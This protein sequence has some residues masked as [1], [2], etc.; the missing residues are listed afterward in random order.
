MTGTPSV[1]PVSLT[2][3]SAKSF[4]VDFCNS[5]IVNS[6]L[7]FTTELKTTSSGRVWLVTQRSTGKEFVLKT[8]HDSLGFTSIYS[9]YASL[10]SSL[11]S[12][13]CYF[14][15]PIQGFTSS[16]PLGIV[17]PS[18]TQ[19]RTLRTLLRSGDPI[20]A[21]SLALIAACVCYAMAYLEGQQLVHGSLHSGKIFLTNDLVPIV[22]DYGLSRTY[23][24]FWDDRRNDQIAW[25]APE[26]LTGGSTNYSIDVYSYGILLF[27]LFESRRPFATLT[28]TEYLAALTAGLFDD[29]DFDTTPENWR[30][31]IRQCTDRASDRRPTF[32]DLYRRLSNCEVTW[33]DLTVAD[34]KA[35]VAHYPI[36]LIVGRQPPAPET[37][38]AVDGCAML[39]N[40][41]HALFEEYIQYLTVALP[42][43]LVGVLCNSLAGYVGQCQQDRPLIHFLLSAVASIAQR[44]GKFWEKVIGS[45]FFSRLHITTLDEADL[46][47]EMLLPVF[48]TERQHF[49]PSIFKSI[50]LLFVFHANEALN[51]MSRYV[52]ATTEFSAGFWNVIRFFLGL[53]SLFVGSVYGDRYVRI[54]SFL[55]SVS[56]EF[57]TTFVREIFAILGQ[58]QITRPGLASLFLVKWAPTYLK[59]SP[60]DEIDLA[61]SDAEWRQNETIFLRIPMTSPSQEFARLLIKR[62]HVS[63]SWAVL[64]KFVNSSESHARAIVRVGGWFNG[65]N[66]DNS[67]LLLLSMFV[68]PGVRRDIGR[69]PDFFLTLRSLCGRDDVEVLH[70]ICSLIQRTAIDDEFVALASQSGFLGEYLKATLE[71]EDPQVARFGIICIDVCARIAYAD[72]W[73]YAIGIL[74]H[75]MKTR[76]EGLEDDFIILMSTMSQFPPCLKLMK[77]EGLYE[78]FQGLQQYEN[79]QNCAEFFLKNA[80][81][82]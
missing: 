76:Y 28:N 12:V 55:Y 14:L 16:H 50:A 53:W 61:A 13:R 23:D 41:N 18:Y 65:S 78:Y 67:F 46:L 33:P 4:P 43:G 35:V 25:V 79:Y 64:L 17:Y 38:D 3:L 1:P 60:Q 39:S 69:A 37:F 51:L 73:I 29:L 40:P 15:A 68:Y 19:L 31:L 21:T 8:I 59:L 6:D 26:L 30:T 48:G 66:V 11:L 70:A 5:L 80:D 71:S 74:I 44:G 56:E 22:T 63:G 72:E 2:S 20:P 82:S 24:Y 54:I 57:R 81:R 42:V 75:L 9:P 27:E 34:F 62:A 7:E 32:R 58:F 10:I 52:K 77:E 36:D 47:L 45:N 49:V